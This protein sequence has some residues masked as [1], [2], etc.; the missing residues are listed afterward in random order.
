M[1]STPTGPTGTRSTSPG[2]RTSDT[3]LRRAVELAHLG[4]WQT[5]I[6]SLTDPAQNVTTWSAEVF[7]IFAYEPNAVVVTDELFF[8]HVPAEDREVVRAAVR[9]ALEADGVY[10][11]EHRI[12]RAD[13][14]VRIVEA[15]GQFERDA[16]GNPVRLIGSVVDVTDRRRIEE[17]LRGQDAGTTL[18]AQVV[19][20]SHDAI[21][22]STLDQVIT[23]WNPAAE[24]L[25]GW[26]ADEVV[27]RRLHML[28]PAERQHEIEER[29][30]AIRTGESAG[31][32][33]TVRQRRDGTLIDVEISLSPIID[34]SGTVIG[35]VAVIRD[36][37]EQRRIAAQ[38]H[39]AQRLESIGRLAG[40]VAHDFNNL[41]MAITGY[42]EL[43]RMDL[44]ADAPAQEDLRAVLASAERGARLTRQLLAFGRRQVL[45]PVH[46][47]LNAVL[48]E[49]EGV[50]RPLAG[51][52]VTLELRLSDGEATVRA[53]RAQ[54]E[55]VVVNLVAN[56][57]DAM[58]HGGLLTVTTSRTD[59]GNGGPAPAPSVAPGAYV[60][61]AVGDTGVGMDP[62]VQA[63]LFEPFFTT[64]P[65]GTSTGM[66]LA[67][68]YGIVK[69]SGGFITVE[70]E[71]DRGSTLRVYLPFHAE[72]ADAPAASPTAPT[73]AVEGGDETI[74]LVEDDPAVRTSA[75]AVML[76][77]GYD[78]RAVA[79]PSEALAI[80]R[81]SGADVDLLLTDVVLPEMSGLE[82]A[83]IVQAAFPHVRILRM[84]GFA[85]DDDV[86]R[87]T[88]I[89]QKP[90]SAETLA[91]AIRDAL[92]A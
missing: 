15:A 24:R 73:S 88:R 72:P 35:S 17:A 3:L 74:L 29:Y 53:D 1:S 2:R 59:V 32:F 20:H 77:L 68:T 79:T 30:A 46:L 13:G 28:V 75:A 34:R 60:C 12:T 25:F 6:R 38:L 9:R 63:R 45:H 19:E 57:R 44:P 36:I 31:T 55:Q 89:L 5:E 62:D 83:D 81:G 21:I 48:R 42:T 7:R 22:S 41:L 40:G 87:D 76:R 52:E 47:D 92:S 50:L 86:P 27:G 10:R 4:V 51:G 18:V 43:V 67:A 61:L 70:S 84:S 64:K 11:T 54:L 39:H 8:S 37:T 78:V 56:A 90:F 82:L 49:M 85:G 69:Q 65:R 80:L 26:K 66:A 91:R 71:R 33:E 23:T 16:S 58:P 14:A